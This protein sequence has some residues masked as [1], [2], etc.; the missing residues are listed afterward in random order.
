MWPDS[1]S[2]ASGLL[3]PCSPSAVARFVV[4][5]VVD[6]VKSFILWAFTHSMEKRF[7]LMPRRAYLYPAPSI[8]SIL[9]MLCV[10][11][12]GQHTAPNVVFGSFAPAVSDKYR[13][14][15]VF[16]ETAAAIC[17]PRLNMGFSGSND[18]PAIATELRGEML[19]CSYQLANSHQSAEPFSGNATGSFEAAAAFRIS[20]SEVLRTH[21]DDCPTIALALPMN[22]KSSGRTLNYIERSEIAEFLPGQIYG[23]RHKLSLTHT[24][25]D[26]K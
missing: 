14:H 22:A 18:T 1:F 8:V 16:E 7:K 2:T 21:N 6:S 5:V 13:S 3:L 25:G 15:S 4:S 19:C 23:Y 20:I 24:S 9:L 11:T 10:L 26:S 17:G 12:A